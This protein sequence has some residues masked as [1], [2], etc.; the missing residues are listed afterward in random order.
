MTKAEAEGV[1][2][3]VATYATYDDLRRQ[4]AEGLLGQLRDGTLVA[5]S[6]SNS[7]GE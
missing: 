5:S 2:E 1:T 7:T 6:G 4:L 3:M